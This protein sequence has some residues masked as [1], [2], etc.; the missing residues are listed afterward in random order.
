MNHARKA[1]LQ[2]I[3]GLIPRCCTATVLLLLA[4]ANQASAGFLTLDL[5]DGRTWHDSN[6]DGTF[7]DGV[8]APGSS[9][10]IAF[11]DRGVRAARS[12]L[13]FDL[14]TLQGYSITKVELHLVFSIARDLNNFDPI[15]SAFA[16]P[17]VELHGSSG[18][19][20]ILFSD[21]ENT[22][23]LGTFTPTAGTTSLLDVTSL[24]RNEAANSTS[25][26]EF[27][28]RVSGDR[29][30]IT[31]AEAWYFSESADQSFRPQ[32]LIEVNPVPE[33][34]GFM[35]FGLG[36]LCLLAL[37]QRRSACM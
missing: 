9:A 12:G 16:P 22:N 29:N 19:G 10:Y 33:P 3:I 5:S 24:V 11:S 17:T 27:S 8:S 1:R 6:F 28:L 7:S 15:D 35:L 30:P 2:R 37:R 18:D 4:N 20:Q 31:H 34:S 26:V 25:F 32:L 21:V 36:G 23:L 14:R 13:A